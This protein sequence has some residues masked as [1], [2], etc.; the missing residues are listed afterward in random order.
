[1]S[2]PSAVLIVVKSSGCPACTVLD[3][4]WNTI[5]LEIRQNFPQIVIHML[6]VHG[7]LFFDPKVYPQDLRRCIYFFP[8]FILIPGTVWTRA[9]KIM[10]PNNPV[11]LYGYAR[12]FNIKYNNEGAPLFE[13]QKILQ[14]GL[15]IY[16]SG[17][18]SNWIRGLLNSSFMYP[19]LSNLDKIIENYSINA[20][21]KFSKKDSPK[22]F[23]NNDIP[24]DTIYPR[25]STSIRRTDPSLA[26]K[27]ITS[28]GYPIIFFKP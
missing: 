1:M 26:T 9:T 18:L 11:P 17:T 21:T 14:E 3:Q 23:V 2:E 13:N 4:N 10:G 12:T 8:S 22:K 24:E 15:N 25:L 16:N 27:Y 19:N 28:T 7:N 20:I 6:T 5:E